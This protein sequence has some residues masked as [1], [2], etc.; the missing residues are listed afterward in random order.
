MNQRTSRR[1]LVAV[2]CADALVARGI[3]SVLSQEPDLELVMQPGLPLAPIDV[4]VTDFAHAMQVLQLTDGSRTAS[5]PRIL[6]YSATRREQEVRLAVAA[7]IQAILGQG[8]EL[9]EFANAI[10][11]IDRGGRYL[12]LAAAQR[13]AISLSSESLTSRELQVLSLLARGECNKTIA[14]QLEVTLGT[15]KAHVGAILAKLQVT[16]RTQAARV[17]VQRGLVDSDWHDM[18]RSSRPVGYGVGPGLFA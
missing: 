11:A 15:A 18:E 7:G 4:L 6:L 8:C 14:T 13:V 16:S 17:A 5:R 12:D 10:R 1:I 2:Q 3:A 9:S